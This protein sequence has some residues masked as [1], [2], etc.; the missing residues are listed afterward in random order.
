M[1]Y[2]L[3]TQTAPLTD[4][5]SGTSEPGRFWALSNIGEAVT[6]ILSPMCWT[7]WSTG[8]FRARTKGYGGLGLMPRNLPVPADQNQLSNGVF[9]GQLAIN[10]D[11][12]RAMWASL[13]GMSDEAFERS[14]TGAVRP[15]LIPT[16]KAYHRLPEILTR[17]TAAML[18]HQRH[19]SALTTSQRSWWQA[20]TTATGPEVPEALVDEALERFVLAMALH[21][22]TRYLQVFMLGRL[23]RLL[24]ASGGTVATGSLIGGFSGVDE[25]RVADDLWKLA[26]GELALSEF[27]HEHGYHGPDE[28]NVYTA[29]WREDPAPV[30]A[31][32]EAL[33]RSGAGS[34]PALR[35]RAA[36]EAHRRELQSLLTGLPAPRRMLV[37]AVLSQ[38]RA[39]TIQ[40]E[41]GKASFLMAIDTLRFAARAAGRSAVDAGAL[42]QPDDI[43]F[44]TID[45]LKRG[46][47]GNAKQ[48]VSYRRHVRARHA[49]VRLPKVFTGVPEPLD[50][51]RPVEQAAE[52]ASPDEITGVAAS[53][54]TAEGV[55]AVVSDISQSRKLEPG[56]ILVCRTTDPSWTPLLAVAGAVVT[57]IGSI[58]SHGAI[59]ARELGIPCIMGTRVATAVLRDGQIATVDGSSG[60]LR[61][62]A[63]PQPGGSARDGGAGL[64]TEQDSGKHAVPATEAARKR[65]RTEP[66]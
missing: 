29:S 50:E 41:L 47:P 18:T 25:V 37:R 49:R 16:K 63:T 42:D 20:A 60:V 57:D 10:V 11:L 58:I 6:G 65:R 23:S 46:I 19:I 8:M 43:F 21:L 26:H 48:L 34:R 14:T 32:A 59:A 1:S 12:N 9:Y 52:A 4:P 38:L 15:G 13:P 39:L 22:R 30:L 51:Q 35:E 7:I 64:H 66:R 2:R 3:S 31:V 56:G 55:I 27:L 40:S 28:G 36:H 33:R 45:E 62:Q 24:T 53:P 44:F 61:I 54:G 5:T 17:C